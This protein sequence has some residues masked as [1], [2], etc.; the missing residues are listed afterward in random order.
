MSEQP[1]PPPSAPDLNDTI[2]AALRDVAAV[3][4][5]TLIELGTALQ[6]AGNA[7]PE[8]FALAPPPD[9]AHTLSIDYE[10]IDVA[11]RD[12]TGKAQTGAART[13]CTCGFDSGRVPNHDA[14]RA[15]NEHPLAHDDETP[16]QLARNRTTVDV[17]ELVAIARREFADEQP[18]PAPTGIDGAIEALAYHATGVGFQLDAAEERAARAEAALDRVR[19][20]A[21]GW[22]IT[23]RDDHADISMDIAADAITRALDGTLTP[24]PTEPLYLST[25]CAAPA[26]G[27]T[28]NWHV[29][30]AGCTA[31][32]SCP[33]VTFQP[34][35]SAATEATCHIG[36]RANAEDCPACRAERQNLPYPF[37][38]PGEPDEQRPTE[39]VHA[40]PPIGSGLTPCCSRNP[41]ELP[42]GDRISSEATVTCPG[43]PAATE[44][45]HSEED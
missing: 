2:N 29:Q 38:C 17:Q 44:A 33:C 41:I 26:C 10:L 34:P 39:F 7:R 23:G 36:G 20:L 4:Q 32:L 31:A 24:A 9:Q 3:Y 35:A 45:T 16:E 13:T 15:F 11:D 5:R 27:H 43:R 30:L 18:E 12:H 14:E 6:K 25:P 40:I 28:L 1:T 8:G 19:R 37:L 21:A 22:A 42:L